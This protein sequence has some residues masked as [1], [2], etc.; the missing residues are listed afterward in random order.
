MGQEHAHGV[1]G[2]LPRAGESG[3]CMGAAAQPRSTIDGRRVAGGYGCVL[4]RITDVILI[5]WHGEH[6]LVTYLKGIHT[7]SWL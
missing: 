6:T 4:L 2:L 5:L 1:G 3:A 7:L